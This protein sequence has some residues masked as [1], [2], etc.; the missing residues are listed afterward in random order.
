MKSVMLFLMLAF[1]ATSLYA[2][3]ADAVCGTW[4]VAKKN[5]KIQITKNSAG[6]YEGKIV[7]GEG[8][9][10][11]D[12]NNP[13]PS[14]RTRPLMGLLLL[15]GFSYEGDSEWSGGQ[16]YDP[17]NGKDYK[18]T[19]TLENPNTLNVRGYI[20]VSLFGRSEKWTRVS[21]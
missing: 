16:I 10:S 3:P 14:L 6:K 1:G 21:E 7:W 8:G 11:L 12:V 15:R 20:G 2:Q 19:L 17:N 13:N 9:D 4:L 18:C 5:G